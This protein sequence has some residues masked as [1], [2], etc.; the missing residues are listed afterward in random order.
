MGRDS[1]KS[2]AKLVLSPSLRQCWGLLSIPT[3][4]THYAD[5]GFHAGAFQRCSLKLM[6][7]YARV[8]SLC[9]S[10]ARIQKLQPTASDP[11]QVE[12]DVLGLWKSLVTTIMDQLGFLIAET[13]YR[14]QFPWSP[15]YPALNVA[16]IS[17]SASRSVSS[18]CIDY[19]TP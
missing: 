4:S 15:T 16:F 17:K 2:V 1:R 11:E 9:A 7:N 12:Q 18:F 5:N 14:C 19:I 8:F 3:D 6:L 13:S 10:L